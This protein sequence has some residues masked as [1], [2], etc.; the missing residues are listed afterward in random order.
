MLVTYT[1]RLAFRTSP[2]SSVT[3]KNTVK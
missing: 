2:G 1:S 3:E